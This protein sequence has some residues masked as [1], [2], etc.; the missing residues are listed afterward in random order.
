MWDKGPQLPENMR[1]RYRTPTT[2]VGKDLYYIGGSTADY[3]QTNI[4]TQDIMIPMTEILIYHIE[5][6]AWEIK[7]ATGVD[8][9]PR[10]RISHTIAAS[11]FFIYT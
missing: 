2:L 4:I 8:N 11:R 7:E 3:N 1:V 10:P 6:M 9:I 5:D